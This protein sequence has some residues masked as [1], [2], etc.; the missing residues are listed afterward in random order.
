MLVFQTRLR[1]LD[2][3]MVGIPGAQSA[4]W[5]SGATS[6]AH[7]RLDRWA[8]SSTDLMFAGIE[9]KVSLKEWM[10]TMK[11]QA[12]YGSEAPRKAMERAERFSEEIRLFR[13]FNV[14]MTLTLT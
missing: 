8:T 7:K 3:R 4:R 6:E 2:A 13:D 14:F 9:S 12:A 10:A 11:E 1:E 5:P